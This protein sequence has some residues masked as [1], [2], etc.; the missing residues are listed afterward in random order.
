[1]VAMLRV[2][3]LGAALVGAALVTGT[4]SGLL[5]V[6]AS[7][8]VAA[9]VDERWSALAVIAGSIAALVHTAVGVDQQ[10]EHHAAVVARGHRPDREADVAAVGLGLDTECPRESPPV[11]QLEVDRGVVDVG[12]LGGVELAPQKR[13]QLRPIAQEL[14]VPSPRVGHAAHVRVVVVG[15]HAE[16]REGHAPVGAQPHPAGDPVECLP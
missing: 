11:G 5:A 4:W 3:V 1:M 14:V 15:A 6:L 2:L 9:L 16:R 10:V 12:A 7:C 13:P 8:A